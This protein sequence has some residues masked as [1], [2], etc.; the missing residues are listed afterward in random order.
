M[1]RFTCARSKTTVQWRLS[2]VALSIT[3]LFSAAVA[4]EPT[5]ATAQ[6]PTPPAE[7]ISLLGQPLYPP[8]LPPSRKHA[9]ETE[10]AEARAAY[11]QNPDDPERIIWLGRRTA[12]LGRY[13]EAIQIYTDGIN[14][15]P[16]DAR[17]YRHRG[18]RYITVRQ[19][20]NAIADLEKAV[21]LI[22]GQADQIE[23]DG[24][25]NK[26]NVPTTT[27]HFNIW[28]HLGL[29]YYLTGDFRNALRCY[30]QCMKVS[31][32]NDDALCAT[33]HWLYMTYRRLGRVNEAAAVLKPI[34]QRMTILENH[35]Y[36]QLLLMYKG[37]ITP[38]RL[39][40]SL[41][42][43]DLD[44]ATVGYGIGNW[45]FYN[46]RPTQARAFFRQVIERPNWAAFGFIAAEAELA[47]SK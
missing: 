21:T 46:G 1:F 4:Q 25:P 38:E 43:D 9:L 19:L 32:W 26:Y 20:S 40:A 24:Q 6:E 10:L 16:N 8:S 14:K 28:Y 27:L 39:W 34:R 29:A 30:R 5:P 36:H 13:R 45:H 41:K 3:G 23:P 31:R 22:R 42:E 44:A 18:H 2:L 37:Q 7:A 47:R 11:E 17:L 15:H 12:Y 35:T 33:S